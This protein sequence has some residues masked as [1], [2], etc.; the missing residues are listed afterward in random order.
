MCIPMSEEPQSQDGQQVSSSVW[1]VG[2]SIYE[3]I[4]FE[5]K[6]NGYISLHPVSSLQSSGTAWS[7][8]EYCLTEYCLTTRWT[9]G[10][11]STQ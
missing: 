10:S 11:V 9:T 4:M 1:H 6:L 5:L 8:V 2:R 3:G 7:T